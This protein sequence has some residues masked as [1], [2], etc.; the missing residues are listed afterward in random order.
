M[1]ERRNKQMATTSNVSRPK[2]EGLFVISNGYGNAFSPE[3]RVAC[4]NVHAAAEV[5]AAQSLTSVVVEDARLGRQTVGTD[6]FGVL[7][8]QWLGQ[9]QG[10]PDTVF[11]TTF[12]DGNHRGGLSEPA[13][14]ELGDHAEKVTFNPDDSYCRGLHEH[15]LAKTAE[16]ALGQIAAYGYHA[17]ENELAPVVELPQIAA[18]R[19]SEETYAARA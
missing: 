8:V 14:T 9:R 18:Q 7:V 13:I 11:G 16:N 12:I 4:N 17:G 6:R 5:A 1:A 3:K 2:V 10:S 19:I 15:V